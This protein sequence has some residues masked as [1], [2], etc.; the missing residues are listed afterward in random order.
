M[1]SKIDAQLYQ[2]VGE[3]KGLIISIDKRLN[4]MEKK[5]DDALKISARNSVVCSGVLSV[6]VA[7]ITAKFKAGLGL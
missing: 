7:I 4:R 2:D 6:A 1:P 3:M 5:N